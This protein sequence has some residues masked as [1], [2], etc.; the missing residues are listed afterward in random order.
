[1]L[2]VLFFLKWDS[3]QLFQ[4]ENST[5]SFGIRVFLG[6]QRIWLLSTW[7]SQIWRTLTEV[8]CISTEISIYSVSQYISAYSSMANSHIRKI[9][10]NPSSLNCFVNEKNKSYQYSCNWPHSV[11]PEK[12]SAFVNTNINIPHNLWGAVWIEGWLIGFH[13]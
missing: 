12:D 2:A 11:R 1:M 7:N 9:P 13:S 8:L 4:W 6:L 10:M 5:Q 3:S